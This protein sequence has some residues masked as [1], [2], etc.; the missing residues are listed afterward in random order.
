MT[1]PAS[2]LFLDH[3]AVL[4]GAELSLRD[5][6]THFRDRGEVVLLED[7]PLRE[8]LDNAG[9]R[10]TLV[11][12]PPSLQSARRES[13]FRRALAVL[14]ALVSLLRRLRPRGRQAKLLYA[15]SQKA[16]VIAA[17]LG[18]LTRRPVIWHLRD[19]LSAEHFSRLNRLVTTRLANRVGARVIANSHA[20]RQSFIDAGGRPDLSVTIHNGISA[21]PYDAVDD[22]QVVTL[23][24]ALG[25][26]RDAF[27]VGVFSRLAPWKGQAVLVDAVA[28][29]PGIHALIVGDALFGEEECKRQIEQRIRERGLADRVHMLGFRRDVPLLM[30]ACDAIAHTSIAP[31]P[32]G[33][34]IVEA[35]LARRP[36]IASDAGGAREIIVSADHG[37]LV[38]PGDAD[39]L[40]DAISQLRDDPPTRRR[41]ARAEAVFT[42]EAML[43]AIDREIDAVLQGPHPG[44]PRVSTHPPAAMPESAAPA[45]PRSSVRADT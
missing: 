32:F 39:A 2:I 23:R 17:C 45:T 9:V 15:N 7:G 34:V 4:G 3:T 8:L 25:L 14:P 29:M 38:T 30:K 27:V 18:F 42:L 37:L 33:R 22:D 31:E 36:V 40:A 43:T 11:H 41:L 35:M 13:G 5:I 12:A 28:R 10:V 44:A 19:M 24:D 21:Q 26:P 20:T 16:F 1:T 6:A